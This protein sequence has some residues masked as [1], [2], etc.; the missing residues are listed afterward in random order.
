MTVPLSGAIGLVRALGMRLPRA[1][2][3]QR[4]FE[5][6]HPQEPHYYIRTWV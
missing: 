4:L 1:R 2:R 3:L 5:R 6:I